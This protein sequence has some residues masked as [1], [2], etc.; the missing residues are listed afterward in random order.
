[1][2]L[3]GGSCRRAAARQSGLQKKLTTGRGCI[4]QQCRMLPAC[5]GPPAGLCP[6]LLPTS[7]QQLAGADAAQE[8]APNT[9]I[10]TVP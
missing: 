4:L 6:S 5:T 8:N 2:L 10:A 9:R 1:M 7:Q 3:H